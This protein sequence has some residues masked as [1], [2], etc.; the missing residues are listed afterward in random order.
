MEALL[1]LP[2]A[3]ALM[4][5][6]TDQ[7][8]AAI[9]AIA[10]TVGAPRAYAICASVRLAPDY[11]GLTVERP[12][13]APPVPIFEALERPLPLIA[14]PRDYWY[15]HLTLQLRPERFPQQPRADSLVVYGPPRQPLSAVRDSVAVSDPRSGQYVGRAFWRVDRQG[16]WGCWS[17]ATESSG[18]AQTLAELTQLL[19]AARGI[20]GD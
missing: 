19:N 6:Q 7:I 4:W 20:Y 18:P 14:R 15:P 3:Q 9:A 8:R 1:F 11:S 16:F 12:P 10:T 2:T 17:D 5:S 13:A